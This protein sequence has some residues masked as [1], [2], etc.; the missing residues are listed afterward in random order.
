MPGDP[1]ANPPQLNIRP[2]AELHGRLAVMA[3]AQGITIADQARLLLEESTRK[4][5]EE[6]PEL[7]IAQDAIAKARLAIS[8]PG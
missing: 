5:F 4:A 7:G 6:H 2:R 8:E 1:E 3:A